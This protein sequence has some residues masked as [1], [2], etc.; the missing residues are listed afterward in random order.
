VAFLGWE[1]V[2]MHVYHGDS[3]G[4]YLGTNQDL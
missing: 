4:E 3:M 2:G 1:N